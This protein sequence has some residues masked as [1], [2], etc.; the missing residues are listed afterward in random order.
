MRAILEHCAEMDAL[1]ARTYQ[2]MSERCPDVDVACEFGELADEESGHVAWWRELLAAWDQGLVPDVVNDTEGLQGHIEALHDELASAVPASVEGMSA[3]QMLAAA[4]RMEFFMLDPTFGEL[5]DLTEPGSVRRRRREYAGHVEHVVE[6]IERNLSDDPLAGFL[7]R[8]LKR[9]WSDNL[10]LA[11]YASRDVLTGLYNR[12]GLMNHMRQWT[13]WSSRYGRALAVLLVDVD[14]F[15]RVN[16]T[17]GHAAGDRT[18]KAVA[19][20][21][22]EAVRESDLVARYGGDEFAVLAPETDMVV[23]SAL[24]S[25][26]VQRT[27]EVRVPLEGREP[28]TVTVSVGGAVTTAGPLLSA[29]SAPDGL[30]AAADRSLYDAKRRGKDRGGELYLAPPSS[31]IAS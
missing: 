28:L 31:G 6:L 7:A 14:D 20:G 18:L 1:A 22:R 8:V 19:E 26:I 11:A 10:R 17:Y 9:A 13:A 24:V 23:L 3:Q 4:A 12:R 16:D 21:L 27:R 29:A 30:L 5:L 2:R 15:K 25:R